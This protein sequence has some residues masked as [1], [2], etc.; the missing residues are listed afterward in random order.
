VA[1]AGAVGWLLSY[2]VVPPVLPDE[3]N[4]L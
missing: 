3:R 4:Q 1:L 2:L